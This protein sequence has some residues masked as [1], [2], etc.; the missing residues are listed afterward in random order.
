MSNNITVAKTE[1][2]FPQKGENLPWLLLP[3]TEGNDQLMAAGVFAA[4][5]TTSQTKVK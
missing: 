5:F 2:G 1:H 4:L 3:L